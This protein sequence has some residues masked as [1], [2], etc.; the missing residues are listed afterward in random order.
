MTEQFIAEMIK[1]APAIAVLLWIVNS[2][3]KVCHLFTPK[4]YHRFTAKLCH[5]INHLLHEINDNLGCLLLSDKHL[6][7]EL[8]PSLSAVAGTSNHQ[9]FGVM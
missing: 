4:L 8:L 9:H 7:F 2:R 5:P 6:L 3:A 1:F